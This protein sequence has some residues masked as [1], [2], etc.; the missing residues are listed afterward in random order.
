V[1]LAARAHPVTPKEV[2]VLMGT[3][4]QA[5][6]VL[7]ARMEAAGYLQ[8][9]GATSDGRVKTVGLTARAHDL[10]GVVEGIYADLE[11]EWA[12]VLGAHRLET[13]R[14]DLRRALESGHGGRL[15]GIRPTK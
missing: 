10:L 6:S 14:A 2:A 5:A 12:Q 3:T 1:L 4:K 11:R 13:I 8:P 9:A 15:P 7:V